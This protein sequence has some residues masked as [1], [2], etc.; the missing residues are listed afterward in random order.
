MKWWD[1]K[2]N[3]IFISFLRKPSECLRLSTD[4]YTANKLEKPPALPFFC[5]GEQ[6][7]DLSNLKACERIYSL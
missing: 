7:K 1:I 6:S 4:K 2:V 5:V 3:R